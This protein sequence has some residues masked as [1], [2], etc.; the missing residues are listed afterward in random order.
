MLEATHKVRCS[1]VAATFDMQAGVCGRGCSVSARRVTA[2]RVE[3]LVCTR[4]LSAAAAGQPA[5]LSSVVS[6]EVM[7]PFILRE[8]QTQET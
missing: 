8:T 3:L 1:E 2:S 5:R 7:H 6:E 4:E